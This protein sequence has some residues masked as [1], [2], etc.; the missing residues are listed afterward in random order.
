VRKIR[1]PQTMGE[2]WPSPGTAV[3]HTVP[4]LSL[5]RVG[6]FFSRLV[7]SPRGPRQHGQFSAQAEPAANVS[8]Q[9]APE[10]SLNHQ[11]AFDFTAGV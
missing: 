8:K 1:L 5:Q 11:E 3:F 4:S 2:E 9:T 10:G 6:G 7:P